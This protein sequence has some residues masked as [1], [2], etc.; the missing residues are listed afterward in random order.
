MNKGRTKIL[1]IV[2]PISG[3]K[4]KS[5]FPNTIENYFQNRN[6]YKISILFTEYK[7]HAKE[8]VSTNIHNHD[9]IVAVGGDGT[10][11]EIGTAMITSDVP[12]G[13]I[14][15]G[16]GNGFAFGLG[17]KKSNNITPYL[18]IIIQQ[19]I[20]TI[21]TALFN[22]IPFLNIAGFGFDGLIVYLFQRQTGRGLFG[23]AKLIM[24]SYFTYK[25]F[26]LITK[27]INGK[28]NHFEN[29]L[30]VNIANGTQPGNHFSVSPSSS[31]TDG[32]LDV[33]IFQKAPFLSIPKL[34]YQLRYGTILNS[35]L[36]THMKS[37]S[38]QFNPKTD[39]HFNIDGEY[40]G[41]GKEV[42]I[43]INPSS[44]RIIVPL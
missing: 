36:V 35:K 34:I 27:T 43:R 25:T 12:L 40:A 31:F 24:T 7:G 32:K 33:I 26:S 30:F 28:K 39:Q 4:N 18:D 15:L 20:K 13:I 11:N 29:V 9:L 17:F 21:D 2:N 14:P 10:I 1:F 23:Y 38:F 41:K 6:E 3:G 44:L 37:K 5:H 22:N 8:I 19:N 42:W 16:S